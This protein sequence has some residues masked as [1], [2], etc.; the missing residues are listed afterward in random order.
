MYT[1]K[2]YPDQNAAR[3]RTTEEYM[4]IAGF[5]SGDSDPYFLW[6]EIQTYLD[7]QNIPLGLAGFVKRLQIFE[8]QFKS[9]FMIRGTLTTFSRSGCLCPGTGK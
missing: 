9:H 1:I 5:Q 2:K 6:M 3:T 8:K 7:G 4:V